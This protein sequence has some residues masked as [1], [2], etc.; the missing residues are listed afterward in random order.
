MMGFIS[1]TSDGMLAVLKIVHLASAIFF[2]GCIYFRT[3]IIHQAK[4]PLGERF[5]EVEGLLAIYSR[6]FGVYNNVVLLISGVW[7]Y[8]L[9]F[10]PSNILL[11]AKAMLGFLIVVIFYSAPYFVYRLSL[12]YAWFKIAFQRMLFVLMIILVVISQLMFM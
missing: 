5:A 12:Q 9:Y 11:H 2:I 7:L 6:R 8:Y 4:A 1:H 3:L 10:D